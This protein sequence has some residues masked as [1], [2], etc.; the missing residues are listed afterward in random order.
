MSVLVHV[1]KQELP[2]QKLL[3]ICV[4][5]LSIFTNLCLLSSSYIVLCF[6]TIPF[7]S[8]RY[9]ICQVIGGN[10]IKIM[11]RERVC[12]SQNCEKNIIFFKE[13]G[14]QGCRP[15]ESASEVNAKEKS[16]NT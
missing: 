10:K 13:A 2:A 14:Q 3:M 1:N 6:T 5:K 7:I 8:V 4:P 9:Q 16:R 11:S 15:S 12:I